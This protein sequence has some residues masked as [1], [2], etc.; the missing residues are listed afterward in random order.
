[1]D[2]EL[3]F[4]DII[5]FV[6]EFW[7]LI[8]SFTVLGIASSTLFFL[9]VP[10]EFEVTAQIKLGQIS[11]QFKMVTNIESPEALVSRMAF[12]TSYPEETITLC[13]L[14]GE[15]NANVILA[16][17]VKISIIMQKEEIVELQIRDSSKAVAETCVYSV[18]QLIKTT[19]AQ[20]AAPYIQEPI[21]KLSIEKKRL[22]DITQVIS[23]YEKL[24]IPLSIIYLMTRDEI[25]YVADQISNLQNIIAFNE[26]QSSTANLITPIFLREEPVYPQR[27]KILLIGLLLGSFSGLLFALALKSY[28]SNRRS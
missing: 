12:P 8:I 1:M 26:Y 17:K 18:Y 22:A 28:R 23:G 6:K 7:K 16:K 2:D 24:E 13:G 4:A 27:R 14:A 19:Q 11:N 20:I 21:K 9:L 15:K 5:D 10:K 25:S 3:S